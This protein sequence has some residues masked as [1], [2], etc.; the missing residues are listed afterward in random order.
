MTML[1]RHAEDL[2]WAGRYVERAQD[3]ARL[4]DVTYNE[5]IEAG[6]VFARKTWFDLLQV[7]SLEATFAASGRRLDAEG[8]TSFLVADR[9]NPGS[10]VIAIE[11]ARENARGLRELLSTELWEAINNAYLSLQARDVAR[12]LDEHPA[13]LYAFV[14]TACQTILGAAAETMNRDDGWRFLML[15][16]QVERAEMTCRLIEV[17]SRR[18][19]ADAHPTMAD[20]S[21]LLESAAA[22]EAYVRTYAASP[23]PA[24]VLGFLLLSR[25]FPRSVFYSLR[26]AEQILQ[27]IDPESGMSEARRILGRMRAGLEFRAI[28]ELLD[29]DLPAHLEA[30]QTDV[31]DVATAVAHRY[32]RMAEGDLHL[33]AVRGEPAEGVRL[34]GGVL[35]S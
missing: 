26:A 10:I 8:L 5:Q 3:T 22:T 27:N 34:P 35:S 9:E 13:Q 12:D 29:D 7:L 21:R 18:V 24:H 19:P 28:D 14:K 11:R 15:G 33:T 4:L 31:L 2:F 6:P 25:T 1:A 30:L 20:W 17:H 23:D 16:V 32:F